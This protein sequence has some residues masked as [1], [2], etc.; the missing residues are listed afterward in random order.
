MA[1]VTKLIAGGVSAYTDPSFTEADFNSLAN[2]SWITADAD[3]DNSSNLDVLAEVSFEFTVGGTTTAGAYMGLWFRPLNR[4]AST[5]GDNIAEG[6]TLPA[7]TYFVGAC[8]VAVGITSGN[9][10]YGTFPMFLLRRGLGRFGISNH[11]GV[12]LHS[13][14]AA[15]IEIRTTNLNLN[16]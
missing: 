7:S 11:C 2:G 16:G 14:A 9:K 6:S 4:T 15:A 8:G 5:Y 13:S 3:F 1:S 10:I 12:A